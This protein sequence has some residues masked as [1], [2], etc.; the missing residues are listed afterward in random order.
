M[1]VNAERQTADGSSNGTLVNA[2]VGAVVTVVTA[3]LPFS[4]VLGGAVA[5]YLQGAD[6]RTGLRV[7]AYS[8]LVVSI[9]AFLLVVLAVTVFVAF[10]VGVPA[11]GAVAVLVFAVVIGLVVVAYFAGLSAL[12]GYV[13]AAIAEDRAEARSVDEPERDEPER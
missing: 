3:F 2:L 11:R 7:G 8:G 4:P 9:P 13:G 12:G 6:R 10:P 1:A 5:G